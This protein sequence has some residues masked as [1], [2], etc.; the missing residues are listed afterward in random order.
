M[1]RGQA[2]AAT[3]S[4]GR[5]N[6]AVKLRGKNGPTRGR[7]GTRTRTD[8]LRIMI[9]DENTPVGQR[10][11]Y[12]RRRRG[13]TQQVLAGRAGCSTSWVSKL[14]R[15]E[16]TVEKIQDLLAIA[17][18]LNVEP[19]DLIGGLACRPTAE[20]HSTRRK[21]SPRSAARCSRSTWATDRHLTP[22]SYAPT[23]SG[24]A[25]APAM[26]G[27]SLLRRTLTTGC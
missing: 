10:I 14:E 18:V 7:C 13:L 20:N 17:R 22:L 3:T 15:G 25:S 4:S 9:M 5:M 23:S 2:T 26:G 24:Q 27:R 1:D 21:G 12:Y 19:G 11:A 8:W 16:R 6:R